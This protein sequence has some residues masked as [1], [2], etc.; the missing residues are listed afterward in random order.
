MSK[1]W[2]IAILIIVIIVFFGVMCTKMEQKEQDKWTQRSQNLLNVKKY[3][4]KT[5]KQKNLF[6][7]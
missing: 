6:K 7:K 1:K 5:L 4:K 2:S 3:P